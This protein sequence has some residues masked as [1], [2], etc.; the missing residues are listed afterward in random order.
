MSAAVCSFGVV[1]LLFVTCCLL[2]AGCNP[3][4]VVS[5]LLLSCV[6][7]C[8]LRGVCCCC[9]LIDMCWLLRE[10]SAFSC[11]LLGARCWLLSVV[12]CCVLCAVWCCL[13]LTVVC[14]LVLAAC[15][16][17][18]DVWCVLIVGVD[19]LFWYVLLRIVVLVFVGL[20]SLV[21]ACTR[22][23]GACGLLFVCFVR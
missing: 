1:C 15:C 6:V 16:P 17:L 22:C 4:F 20:R 9:L 10:V 7:C 12:V 13:V 5:W 8:V 21:V 3:L 23:C 19:T 11:L 18:C 2:C 14:C